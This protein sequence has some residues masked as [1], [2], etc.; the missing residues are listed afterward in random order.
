LLTANLLGK[1]ERAAA[2]TRAA[3]IMEHSVPLTRAADAVEAAAHLPASD[4]A[5]VDTVASTAKNLNE[6]KTIPQFAL[7]NAP[8]DVEAL[9]S[10]AV[11][12]KALDLLRKKLGGT[13]SDAARQAFARMREE[14]QLSEPQLVS[15]MQQLPD[16]RVNTFGQA[17]N[18]LPK[19]E[20]LGLSPDAMRALYNELARNPRLAELLA[21]GNEYS[22]LFAGLMKA[23]G[24][25]FSEI[26]RLLLQFQEESKVLA[27]D[28][29]AKLIEDVA[30]GRT[31]A[32]EDAVTKADTAR[33]LSSLAEMKALTRAEVENAI[34]LLRENA[35][36]TDAELVSLLVDGGEERAQKLIK[37]VNNLPPLESLVF[38]SDHHMA[39]RFFRQ[40][41]RAPRSLER[42]AAGDVSLFQRLYNASGGGMADTERLFAA[43]ERETARLTH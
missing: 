18:H 34:N 8:A 30:A 14:G 42:L 17:I 22:S 28:D 39:Q 25:D 2:V 21:R 27:K 32:L 13:I 1:T 33:K 16:S 36:F 40:L 11:E 20:L 12:N 4:L 3:E 5:K 38:L 10:V 29:L 15:L 23:K 41:S 43:L 6:A 19:P 35:H 9:Q 26:E 7:H 37:A 24:Q 31:Q